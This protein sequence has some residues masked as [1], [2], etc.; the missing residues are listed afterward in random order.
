[1]YIY[2]RPSQRYD[3][4]AQVK[5]LEGPTPQRTAGVIRQERRHGHLDRLA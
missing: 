2:D 3:D 4:P 1:M 5:G